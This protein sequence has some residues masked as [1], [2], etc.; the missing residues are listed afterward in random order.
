MLIATSE[1]GEAHPLSFFFFFL[2]RA[3]SLYLAL[4]PCDHWS[5]RI[6]VIL[7]SFPIT[8][9]NGHHLPVFAQRAQ[10]PKFPTQFFT[11]QLKHNV[12]TSATFHH[13][14]QLVTE[15]FKQGGHVLFAQGIDIDALKCVEQ[16]NFIDWAQELGGSF[17]EGNWRRGLKSHHS[18]GIMERDNARAIE[19]S[20]RLL[21]RLRIVSIPKLLWRPAKQH[22]EV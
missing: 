14:H 19:A 7:L 8:P 6:S 12:T 3:R 20:R 16:I 15:F 13:Q 1:H 22:S 18:R 5:M 9:I 10:Y 2:S 11:R 21:W 4:K 17:P